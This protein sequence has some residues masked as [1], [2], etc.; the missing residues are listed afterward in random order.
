MVVAAPM[1]P[2]TMMVAATAVLDRIGCRPIHFAD[3]CQRPGDRASIGSP[4]RC[5]SISRFN[6]SADWYRR[7]R[8]FAKAFRRIASKSPRR[9]GFAS[10][11]LVGSFSRT[12]VVAAKRLESPT[13]YG[14]SFASS[15]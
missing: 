1:S 7:S 4:A 14:R 5:R 12:I 8:S 13:S 15:S 3:R 11:G 10:D 6:C 2:I 9:R